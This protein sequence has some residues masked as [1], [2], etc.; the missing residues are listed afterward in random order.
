[1]QIAKLI[2]VMQ[3]KACC[4]PKSLIE[5]SHL[6]GEVDLILLLILAA[7]SNNSSNSR[8]KETKLI[9]KQLEVVVFS[10]SSLVQHLA[11]LLQ[12]VNQILINQ[13]LPQISIHFLLY[14]HK[15]QQ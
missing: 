6:M 1:M 9:V 14:N 15:I 5:G 11:A 10:V 2:K 12:L 13:S 8:V 3:I 7:F 4:H